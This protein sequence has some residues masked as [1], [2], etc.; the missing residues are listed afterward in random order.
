MADLV[1]RACRR[2]GVEAA[3]FSG[4]SLRA[5]LF[6]SAAHLGRRAPGDAFPTVWGSRCR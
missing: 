5:G 2:A 3:E 1:K 4:H 6:T